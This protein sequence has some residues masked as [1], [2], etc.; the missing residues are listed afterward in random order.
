MVVIHRADAT[1]F[2]THNINVTDIKCTAR[3][4]KRS[5]GTATAFNLGF[6]NSTFGWTVRVS[7]EFKQFSLKH[8]GFFKFVETHFGMS[9]NVNAKHVTA[10]IFGHNFMAEKLVTDTLWVSFRLVTFIDSNDHRTVC[11]TS[12]VDR[13]DGLLHDAI[14]SGNNK[15]DDVRDFRTAHPHFGESFVARRVNKSDDIAGFAFDLIRP[16]M[17]GDAA[18]FASSNISRTNSV[19][20]RGFTVVN[21]T[22]DSNNRRTRLHI[23]FI[24]ISFINDDVNVSF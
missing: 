13:F 24:F 5:N 15:D 17:L 20:N 12:V 8:D 21:V 9:R 2:R 23:A 19:K 7:F 11:G 22:H 14:I 3:D 1:C 18:R 6:N 4:E 10:E 16:D